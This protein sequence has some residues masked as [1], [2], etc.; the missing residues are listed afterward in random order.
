MNLNAPIGVFDSGIGGLSIQRA[1]CAALPRA[2]FAY[3]ADSG[4]APYGER[5]PEHALQRALWVTD[6]LRSHHRIQA[7]VIACNTATA[8]AIDVLRQRHPDLPFIGVEPAVKPAAAQ[9]RTGRITVWATRSTLHSPRFQQLIQRLPCSVQVHS[10]ACDG[11]AE[12][13]EGYAASGNPDR[14]QQLCTQYLA[15]GGPYGPEANAS[16]LLV[17][18]CTHYP[19]VADYLQAALGPQVQLQ[20]PGTAVAR[21]LMRCLPAVQTL[22]TSP[23]R[24]SAHWLG[25][26]GSSTALEQAAMRWLGWQMRPEEIKS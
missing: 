9:T 3:L 10:V 24:P 6:Y 17:L 13:I 21:Q 16:D 23:D 25:C 5:S 7:L 2:R 26:T 15:Q 8:A 11:L 12:A 18:G 19:L 22:D 4:F 20:D 14:V 1:L